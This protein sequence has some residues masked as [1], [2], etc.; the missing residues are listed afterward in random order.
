MHGKTKGNM[1]H[2]QAM[3]CV[4]LEEWKKKIKCLRLLKT[5]LWILFIIEG[6]NFS[7][8]LSW[9]N[10]NFDELG[11]C[12]RELDKFSPAQYDARNVSI[13]DEGERERERGRRKMNEIKVENKWDAIEPELVTFSSWLSMDSRK[14]CHFS[15]SLPNVQAGVACKEGQNKSEWNRKRN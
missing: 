7:P 11:G 2:G 15:F 9:I 14:F 3:W 1:H 13:H 6:N 4:S 5:A 8:L 10:Q 12:Y